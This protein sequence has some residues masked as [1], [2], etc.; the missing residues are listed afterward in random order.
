[1]KY[2]ILVDSSSDLLSNYIVD[3]NVGFAVVPLT[4]NVNGHS[5]VDDDNVDTLSL[6]KDCDASSI[7]GKSACPS[8]NDFGKY[9]EDAEII[10]VVTISS[11]L[12]GS[13]NSALVAIQNSN[14]KKVIVIDSLAVAGTMDLIVDKAFAL[15]KE[16]ALSFEELSSELT[17]YR[18]SLHLYFVLDK[19]DN[20]M[21][22]GRMNKIVARIAS[23]LLIKPLSYACDGQIKILEKIRTSKGAY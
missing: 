6:L 15:C 1:M 2:K 13:Y 20:L 8:P 9:Y 7:A 4:I 3:E 21:K 12:S 16:D 19:F 11:K 18:D 22:N 23:I 14:N 10:I 5:Y 17:K